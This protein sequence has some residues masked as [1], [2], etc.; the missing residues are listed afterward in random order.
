MSESE[1]EG[2]H[3]IMQ[4]IIVKNISPKIFLFKTKHETTIPTIVY[5]KQ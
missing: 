3:L 1:I 4:K 5:N 2:F